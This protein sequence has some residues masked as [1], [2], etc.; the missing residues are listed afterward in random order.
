[1]KKLFIILAIMVLAMGCSEPQAPQFRQV[2]QKINRPEEARAM[3]AKVNTSSLTEGGM[4]EYGLLK[5][6]VAYKTHRQLENDSLIS[7]SIDY[8]NL[9]GGD[10]LRVA[11][12]Y[13]VEL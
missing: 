6:I 10:W 12:I 9:H 8:Y 3:L 2:W 5:T 1:M 11:P 7:A 4:A 13:I